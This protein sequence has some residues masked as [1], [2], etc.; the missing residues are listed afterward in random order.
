MSA[1]SLSYPFGFFD[2]ARLIAHYDWEGSDWYRYLTWQRTY[3]AWTLNLSGFWNPDELPLERQ[4]DDAT[5]FSGKGLQL[6]VT[7][8]H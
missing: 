6:M 8:N 1:A 3:D 5:E 4:D 7:F 2:S